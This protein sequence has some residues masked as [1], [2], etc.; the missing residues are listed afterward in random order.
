MDLLVPLIKERPEIAQAHYLLATAYLQQQK[1]ERGISGLPPDD[2]T[3][4]ERSSAAVPCGK[5]PFVTRPAS[6]STKG[7]REIN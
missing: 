4:P 2:G 7:V 3:I 1:E 6:A 5:H